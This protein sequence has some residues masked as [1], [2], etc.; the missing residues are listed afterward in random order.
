M[1]AQDAVRAYLS[2]DALLNAKSYAE[3]QRILDLVEKR[4]IG[5]AAAVL[6]THAEG[7]R[8]SYLRS[9]APEKRA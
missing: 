6:R 9:L 4:R 1:A 5:E 2:R 8:D 3:H 7:T